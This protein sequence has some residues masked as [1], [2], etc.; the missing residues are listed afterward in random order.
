MENICHKQVQERATLF[1]G[2]NQLLDYTTRI[3]K[4]GKESESCLA[5]G[6]SFDYLG[7][8][9]SSL[10][11]LEKF[12]STPNFPNFSSKNWGLLS[13]RAPTSKR[14]NSWTVNGR[15]GLL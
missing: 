9:A 4:R 14:I 3:W 2:G 6:K 1:R 12:S 10:F 15:L 8:H 5:W 13:I 7:L 11:A